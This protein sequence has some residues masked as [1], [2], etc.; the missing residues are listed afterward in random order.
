M[1]F[2]GQSDSPLIQ[3][4]LKYC[5]RCGGLFLRPLSTTIAYCTPCQAHWMKLIEEVDIVLRQHNMSQAKGRRVR[6]AHSRKRR[7]TLLR[8][9]HGCGFKEVLPC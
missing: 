8:T 6:S 1:N 9:L 4:E 3:R 5:E 7:A 2:T